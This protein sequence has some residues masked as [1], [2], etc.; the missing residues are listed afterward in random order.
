MNFIKRHFRRATVSVLEDT[1]DEEV[2]IKRQTNSAGLRRSGG[3]S[4][5]NSYHDSETKLFEEPPLIEVQSNHTRDGDED[6]IV[7]PDMNSHH[8]PHPEVIVTAPSDASNV[9]THHFNENNNYQ[10]SNYHLSPNNIPA[11]ASTTEGEPTTVGS[12]MGDEDKANQMMALY[13]SIIRGEKSEVKKLLTAYP[14]LLEAPDNFGRTPLMYCVLSDRLECAK[15]LLKLKCKL[16]QVDKAGRSALHLAAH[17]ASYKFLELLHERGGNIEMKDNDGQTPLHLTTRNR[18]ARCL[19]FLLKRLGPGMVEVT[20][21]QDRT[22][23][24]WSAAFNNTE[25]VKL[26]IKYKCNPALSD[27]EGKTPLHW[28][29]NTHDPNAVATVEALL[30]CARVALNWQDY[31]GRTALHFAVAHGNLPVVKYLL[32][33]DEEACEVNRLDHTYRTPLHWAAQLGNTEIV[34]LLLS[35]GAKNKISDG[36]GATPLLYAALHNKPEVVMEMMKH[37]A[38]ILDQSDIEGR[39]ALMWAAGKGANDVIQ[40]LFNLGN[41]NKSTDGNSDGQSQENISPKLKKQEAIMIDINRTDNKGNTA[42]HMAAWSGCA[43]SAELLLHFNA[44]HDL[45]N[46]MNHTPLFGACEKGHINVVKHLLDYNASIFLHDQEERSPLHW[47]ALG[48]HAEICDLL[49]KK[50]LDPDLRDTYKRSP[51][52]CAA[53][54]GFINCMNLLLEN[55]ANVDLQDQEGLSALH[56]AAQSGHLDAT[57]LLFQYSAFPNPMEYTE[58]RLTP[59]DHALF[60]ERDEVAQYLIE[61]GAL[62]SETIRHIA[63]AQIQACFRGHQVRK[64]FLH[65]KEFLVRHERLRNKSRKDRNRGKHKIHSSM[66]HLNSV[67]EEP[68]PTTPNTNSILADSVYSGDESRADILEENSLLVKTIQSTSEHLLRVKYTSEKPVIETNEESDGDSVKVCEKNEDETSPVTQTSTFTAGDV[69]PKRSEDSGIGIQAEP[70]NNER[71]DET[72]S[73]DF[74]EGQQTEGEET[75]HL[76]DAPS[77]GKAVIPDSAS[78]RSGSKSPGS[79]SPTNIM[80][81]EKEPTFEDDASEKDCKLQED[82]N[83]KNNVILGISKEPPLE[84]VQRENQT[85]SIKKS[86]TEESLPNLKA[87]ET[88]PIGTTSDAVVL[89]TNPK[90]RERLK[91]KKKER[92]ERLSHNRTFDKTSTESE[93]E[94]SRS[95]ESFRKRK[96][97]KSNEIKTKTSVLP[98]SQQTDHRNGSEDQISQTTKPKTVSKS[99]KTVANLPNQTK[100]PEIGGP[101]VQPMDNDSVSDNDIIPGIKAGD[102]LIHRVNGL[103]YKS[104]ESS[105]F[106]VNNSADSAPVGTS[107]ILDSNLSLSEYIESLMSIS[108]AEKRVLI[109]IQRNRKN[110]FKQATAAAKIIQNAWRGYAKQ[111]YPNRKDNNIYHRSSVSETPHLFEVE[112]VSDASSQGSNDEGKVERNKAVPSKSKPKEPKKKIHPKSAVNRTRISQNAEKVSVK[113]KKRPRTSRVEPKSEVRRPDLKRASLL[114]DIIL[115]PSSHHQ[116]K[117]RPRTSHPVRRKQKSILTAHDVAVRD[118]IQQ[119]CKVYVAA[120]S[121]KTLRPK[122]SH[123]A[124]YNYDDFDTDDGRFDEPV[125]AVE[126]YTP[127][128]RKTSSNIRFENQ[129]PEQSPRPS[130]LLS[131][132]RSMQRGPRLHEADIAQLPLHWQKMYGALKMSSALNSGRKGNS[133]RFSYNMQSA[134]F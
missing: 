47:A 53:F 126:S 94:T 40:M 130:T 90:N 107:G 81:R 101:S 93:K 103:A 58:E 33:F 15:L 22:A 9:I 39:N 108:P 66:D 133:T 121:W 97:Q 32:N 31:E 24:H 65:R 84:N 85:S 2:T 109:Q 35:F 95:K 60:N 28:A 128:Q 29:A 124:F 62:S 23:L 80:D 43:R 4:F 17:K 49:I 112:P 19:H 89:K 64:E 34:K 134:N 10:N 110:A 56:W 67:G 11:V 38:S 48:G 8:M 44:R 113:K 12:D 71:D 98:T 3:V 61:Q 83:E 132:R 92:P 74:E 115:E 114:S 122:T 27:K 131:R 88:S 116:R 73:Q 104:D 118:K 105:S 50:G 119:M 14:D 51:L 55:K 54:G 63:A 59:L 77:E 41:L 72:Y 57:K 45:Q 82:E 87:R 69:E 5:S 7:V 6:S 79:P 70:E 25:Y 106:E 42:L 20:D 36:N 21:N 13:A 1:E 120:P 117:V 76:N 102:I 96:S 125:T 91:K 99:D 26:L 16:D 37:D 52:L 46:N 86:T 111:K 127:I 100:S 129:L 30:V 123:M 18:H 75:K 68:T 78:D